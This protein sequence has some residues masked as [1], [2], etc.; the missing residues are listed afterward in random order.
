MSVIRGSFRL[1]LC[2]LSLLVGGILVV[3]TS[4]IPVQIKGKRLSLWALKGLVDSLL[5]SL[6]VKV[7]APEAEKLRRHHGFI[8]PNHVSYVDILVL[9]S[10]V[11]VRYLAK[12]EVRSWPIVGI[13]AKAIGCVFVKRESKTSRSQAREA[14]AN[15]EHYYPP[16]ALFPEGKRGPGA[17]LLPFRYGAFEIAIEGGV[18]VLPCAITYEPLE[19]AIWHRGENVLKALWRVASYARPVRCRVVPLEKIDPPEDDDPISLSE[20]TH[21]AMTAVVYPEREAEAKVAA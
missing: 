3:I 5:L 13:V 11:P 14:L 21:A 6:N 17:H 12:D 10:I 7:D 20:Q 19:I 1:L 9:L 2:G 16:V 4:Y 15:V 8:F 18:S